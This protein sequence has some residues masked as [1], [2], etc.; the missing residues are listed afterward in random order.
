MSIALVFWPKQVFSYYWCPLLVFSLQQDNHEGLIYTVSSEQLML[1]CVCFWNSVK[2]LFGLQSEVQLSLMNLSSAAEIT[3]GIPF[4]WQ[5]SWE[6]MP[7]LR[8]MVC[9]TALEETLKVLVTFHIDWPSCLCLFD[10]S[11][12]NMDLVFCQIGLSSV[13][14]PYLVTTKLIGSNALRR[15]EIPQMNF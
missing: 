8:L 13:Y 4:L 3:L 11:F 14:Q 10:L 12:H 15:K 2:H 5:S 6:E 1:R 9:A 7:S